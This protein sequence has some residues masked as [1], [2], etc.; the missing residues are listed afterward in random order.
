MPLMP[1]IMMIIVLPHH[2]HHWMKEIRP[3]LHSMERKYSIGILIMPLVCRKVFTG[4][5]G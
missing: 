1:A 4:P 2:I 3:R 5:I